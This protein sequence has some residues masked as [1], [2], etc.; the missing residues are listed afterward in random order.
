MR[1]SPYF[2]LIFFLVACKTERDPL[3]QVQ[4]TT[5]TG[6]DFVNELIETDSFNIV[7][8]EYIYNGGGVGVGDFDRN[9]LPDLVFSGNR[10]SSELY[11]QT[12]PWTFQ[13]ATVPA[14]LDTDVWCAGVSIH[15]V[16]GNG[17][18]DI[19]FSTLNLSGARD[20]P[21][22]LF[23]N[24]GPAADGIPRFLEAAQ[25]IGLADS[26]YCTQAAWLDFDRDGDLDC[27]LLNNGI[28]DFNRNVPKGPDTVGSGNSQDV[29][30]RNEGVAADG[31]PRFT[32]MP[33][34]FGIKR[35]GWGLG[36]AI[37]D[38]N[39]DGY[40]DIYAAN[41]F[42]SS[43]ILW[44]NE[45]GMG[46]TDSVGAYFPH[47]SYNSMGV[48]MADLNNDGFPELMAVDMLP[49]D[50]ARIKS[51]FADINFDRDELNIRRGYQRQYVRNV[52]QL[53]NG[54]GSF[55]DIGYL[56]G[57]AGTDWSWAPLLCD[58]DNDGHRDIYVTNGYPKDITDL[59]F[60][61][62]NQNATMFGT[63]ETRKVKVTEILRQLGGVH[64]PNYFFRNEGGLDFK[65][66][67]PEWSSSAP[68][69]SNG[70]VFVDLDLDGDLDLV[71][72]DINGPA[73]VYR[74][75]QR[76]RQPDAAHYL[77][78][79][80]N[81]PKG[82]PDGLG[83][84]LRLDLHLADEADNS[85]ACE[86]QQLYHEH[87]RVRG[88]LSTVEAPVHFGLGALD[89][90]HPPA[91]LSV[92]WPDGRRQIIEQPPVDTLIT[93]R[94][95]DAIEGV[96]TELI[97]PLRKDP[98]P[99]QSLPY[100]ETNFNDFNFQY[101]LQRRYSE[102]G[103]H[104]AAADF[105][106]DGLADLVVGGPA[107]QP[108]KLYMR[109]AETDSFLLLDNTDF[110]PSQAAE[111]A[112]LTLFDADGDG[113]QDLYVGNGSSEFIGRPEML[114]DQF[115]LNEGNGRF[116]AT[117]LPN[118]PDVFTAVVLPFDAA[119][120]GD[121][122][123]LILGRMTPGEYPA[124]PPAYVLENQ[125]DGNFTL[126]S[127]ETF[128]LPKD[129]MFTAAVAGDFDGDGQIDLVTAG[130]YLPVRLHRR[131]GPEQFDA[132]QELA[133]A[134]WWQ[135][136][137]AIDWNEDGDLDLFA[138]NLGLNGPLRASPDHPVCLRIADYDGNGSIDPIVSA[139]NDGVAYPVHPRNVLTRQ[140]PNLKNQIPDFAT[141][142]RLTADQLPRAP[143]M[144]ERC[145]TEF[146]SLFLE[147]RSSE[148]FV[149]DPLPNTVQLAPLRGMAMW[150]EGR[151]L[152]VGNDHAYEVLGGHYDAGIGFVLSG[153]PGHWVVD[154]RSLPAAGDVHS[155]Q[156]LYGSGFHPPMV[157][158]GGQ[159]GIKIYY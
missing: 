101:L 116:R 41:D 71:T 72:N 60:A 50:N 22:L 43:D 68:T 157:A 117:E 99:W 94:H 111:T 27:Y 10:V 69:Y 112:T 106:R 129:G 37:H 102:E 96:A 147:N 57:V 108:V 139:Y 119:E 80:L 122:D 1:F 29:L 105:N 2:L 8:S 33:I 55:S 135:S 45:D 92:E 140:L 58:L 133:P 84:K 155:I 51:M 89:C 136:L 134:G 65:V 145:A 4:P 85:A 24:Q 49:D 132:P 17:Y 54:D 91:R 97:P 87:Y 81:G 98:G 34:S 26:S 36:V 113:D 79:A 114:R 130:E 103:P 151:L 5:A 86:V 64:Q 121:L 143:E 158:T 127:P 25:I 11:L 104:L 23:L 62:Y 6:I 90:G 13:K 149:G 42:I 107:G 63:D 59:D 31:L 142:G 67:N 47:Q 12:S 125:G 77:R 75:Y 40:P 61:N 35:E 144:E 141:Y 100:A 7:V 30:Y 115:Y 148:G 16:D 137:L 53:N 32:K 48:D 150:R 74:N 109:S 19:Y 153:R 38:F 126:R 28:E 9:G 66:A 73:G 95:Q 123:L 76:E 118:I 88:Y 20:V 44:M 110:A 159:S 82:N 56:A 46:F 152:G 124:S 52:L 156:R 70:A 78:V 21:N 39:Q 138:G 120:D 93:L 131:I 128:G 154:R 15:D 3:F 83:A 14:G 146:R 18:E